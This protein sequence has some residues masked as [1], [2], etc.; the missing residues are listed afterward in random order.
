VT[1]VW[2][3]S[4]DSGSKLVAVIAKYCKEV[5]EM[6][7]FLTD[8]ELVEGYLEV[9]VKYTY[10]EDERLVQRII[11]AAPNLRVLDMNDRNFLPIINALPSFTTI[12]IKASGS[13]IDLDKCIN[14][15]KQGLKDL[16]PSNERRH[17]RIW[18]QKQ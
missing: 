7:G 13:D 10:L 16:G 17:I 5:Q 11:E 18:Q 12:I 14:A 6:R 3:N 8:E 15:T 2:C 9:L 4:D 1:E